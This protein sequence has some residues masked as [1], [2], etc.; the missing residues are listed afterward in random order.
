[1]HTHMYIH[2]C[3][4]NIQE[5]DTANRAKLLAFTCGSGRLPAQGFAGLVP[6][7]NIEVNR[8]EST[9]NLPSAHTCFNQLCLPNYQEKEQLRSKLLLAINSDAGFGFL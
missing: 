7:F 8:A 3:I 6:P 9:E 5:M 4:H 1:M 2:I